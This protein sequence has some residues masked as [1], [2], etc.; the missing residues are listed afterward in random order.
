M[1]IAIISTPFIRVPP[2]GYGGTELFCYEL[3]EG[4]TW[5]GHDVT[6][7]TTGDSKVT[8]RRRALF[9]SA[10]WP[11]S[12]EDEL[13]HVAWAFGE[14]AR[15]HFDVVQLNSS[16]GVPLTRGLPVPVV[17]T[18]H[19][20]RVEAISRLYTRHP[21]VWYVAI[22]DRQRR[23]EVPLRHSRVIHHGLSPAR[24]PPALEDAGYLAHIGRYAKE[25]G[26]HLAIDIARASGL[27]LRLA[28]RAHP[29]DQQYFEEQVA[30]RLTDG[31]VEELGEADHERKITLLR[32]ARALLC[33]L[34]W[35]EPFGLIA[36]EAML[37][38]TPVLGFRRG[39]FPE[40]VDEGVTGYLAADGD[41]ETLA[42]VAK[43]L[44]GFDRAACARRARE[45]F[46][47]KVMVSAYEALYQSLA[48][49]RGVEQRR[50]A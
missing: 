46:S 14:I 22:S 12:V 36:V 6:L 33:P 40:L 27:P 5:R 21:E 48:R 49:P 23:L 43:G 1:R 29:K 11:P 41:I 17:H 30:P 3:A 45:R 13:N 37:C 38:G 35:E 24:Y 15:D 20:E 8:C 50:A 9:S 19:H 44:A 42:R 47:A 34:Q 26:T 16:V 39:S 10:Q 2:R 31:D 25:K 28:G 32:G 4:L 18:L 7:F